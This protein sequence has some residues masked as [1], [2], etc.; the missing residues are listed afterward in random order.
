MKG[1]DATNWGAINAGGIAAAIA[2]GGMVYADL[3][4]DMNR[5]NRL[6]FSMN[7]QLTVVE[8]VTADN[9]EEINNLW[10]EVNAIKLAQVTLDGFSNRGGRG[11]D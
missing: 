8:V 6:L 10:S 2:L 5:A 7:G 9:S 11:A 4:E 1:P 3:N